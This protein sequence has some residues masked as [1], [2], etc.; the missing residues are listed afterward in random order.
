MSAIEQ[1]L[2]HSG[3]DTGI[4]HYPQA[5]T[6]NGEVPAPNLPT[7]SDVN[8]ELQDDGPTIDIVINNVVCSFATCC[9]LNLKRIATEGMNVEYKRENGMVNMK[10]RKPSATASIW[11][12]GKITCTG[13]TSEEHSRIAG[14]RIARILQRM[15]FKVRFSNFR[16]VNVLG[17]CTLPFTI[18]IIDFS[19]EH[20][21]AASYEPE[22]H[23][24]VTY[25][26][27][28]PKAT[29]KIFSTGSITVTAPCVANVQS[30][31]EHIF[32]LVLEFKGE[33]ISEEE[34]LRKRIL[35][36]KN[37]RPKSKPVVSY[38]ND[39]DSDWMDM[40]DD[41]ELDTSEESFD[42][43]DSQD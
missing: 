40:E 13:A 6:G 29:L 2:A 17:T 36:N 21:Q 7:H 42:S 24:G 41:S 34:L 5:S 3:G 8:E 11:S 27:K 19:R 14:R 10:L 39:V 16:V 12:S 9:H 18:K 38:I 1:T 43:E 31:I 32:P 4:G 26:I 35:K 25:R 22:L 30:A 37:K 33:D 15:G 28:N 23:P 20:R